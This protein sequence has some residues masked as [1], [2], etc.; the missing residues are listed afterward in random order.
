M[1]HTAEPPAAVAGATP[2]R[3]TTYAEFWPFYLNEHSLPLTRA[4][5]FVG[6]SLVVALVAATVLGGN[7]M[8]LL[9]TPFAGY[10]FAW[11]AHFVVEKNKPASF[12]SPGWSFISD[13]RMWALML[14]GR[15]WSGR[16]PAAQVVKPRPP[17]A[18]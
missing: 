12:K 4:L 6:T 15:L 7:A 17:G 18:R 1:N 14:T 3:F 9:A 16:D 5:H 2:A 11:V 13:W 10:G 8:L